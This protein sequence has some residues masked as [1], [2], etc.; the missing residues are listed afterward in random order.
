MAL[1]LAWGTTAWADSGWTTALPYT[2]GT[3]LTPN[4]PVVGGT[5]YGRI[6]RLQNSGN[7]NGTLIATFEAWPYDM[8]I[9]QSTDDGFTWT[10]IATTTET[11]FPGWAFKVEPDLFELP[12]AMGSLPA[13]TILLAGNA[14]NGNGH[15]LE[16][17]FS[18]DHGYTWHYRGMADNNSATLK[19]LWEPRLGASSSGQLVCYYSDERFSP[20]YNQLLGERVSPDGGLTW[21]AEQYVCAIPDAVQRPGMAVTTK[22]PNGQYVLSFEAVGTPTL[23]QVHIKFSPDG[24][25]WGTG[26]TDY[27]TPVQTASG[28][29]VGACPYITWCPAGGSNGTLVINAQFLLNSPNTDREILINTN[30]GQGSWTMMPAPVQWQGGGNILAGWS[31][32]MIPT[33]DGQGIIQLASSVSSN[34]NNNQMLFGREQLVLP[35][36]VYNYFNQNSG[37]ALGIPGNSSVPGTG[38][39]QAV[40]NG[41]PAQQWIFSDQG[42]NVWTVTNPGNQLAWDDLAWNTAPG[43]TVDEFTY[44]GLPVQQWRLRPVGNGSWKFISVNAGLPLSVTN[45]S[46][47]PGAAIVLGTNASK[48]EQNWFPAQPVTAPAAVYAL[49]GTSL[50][51]SGNG[52]QGTFLPNVPNFMAGRIGPQAVQ[53]NGVNNYLQIPR[54]IGAGSGFAIAFWLKTTATGGPGTNWYNGA[55]LVDGNLTAVTNDFG[56]ALLNGKIAFGIGN[57]DTTLP[58]S[59]TV[60]DGLWHHVMA[61]RNALNGLMSLYIDGNLNTNAFGPVGGRMSPLNLRIGSLQTGG[62]GGFFNGALDEV[63]LYNGWLAT[64]QIMAL[65][66]VNS[67]NWAA[68]VADNW[69]TA[70]RWTSSP[71]VPG[72][73]AG[74]YAGLTFDLSAPRTITIDTTS[75]TVGRLNLGDPT[76]PYFG[77]TLAA[78]GGAQLTFNNSGAGASL[79]QTGSQATDV[80]TAPLILADTLTISNTATLTLAGPLT[81]N[82]GSINKS[83]SGTVRLAALD[84][85]PGNTFVK[86]GTL[87]VDTGG[88]ITNSTFD[89]VGQTTGDNATV[90]LQGRGTWSTASDFNAGDIGNS[91]GIVNITDSATLTANALFIGSAN[92]TAS[93]AT[94][95][96]N[97]TNG[98]VT[99]LSPYDGALVIGGRNGS[100]ALGAG[101]Y[102]LYGGALNVNNGGNAWIGGYGTGAFNVTG[103]QATLSGYVSV[104]RWPGAT[105]SL[106]ISGGSVAQTNT[107]RFTLIGEAG[108]GSLNLSGTGQ[109]TV[110]GMQLL[111]GNIAGTGTGTVNLNGGLLVAPKIVSG[112]GTSTINFN[113]GTLAA[114]APAASFMTGLTA[115]N[116][117]AGGATLDDGGFAITIGQPLLNGGSGGLTK[118]GTGT[119]TLNGI[120]TYTG[121][122]LISSG[123]L[124]LGP[125]GSLPGTALM[126]VAA[127]ASFDVT[128]LG[129]PFALGAGQVLSNNAAATG[130]L[131]GSFNTGSGVVYLSYAAGTP[132][133]I[134]TSGTLSL[135]AATTV[136]VN[137]VGPVLGAGSYELIAP[138]IGGAVSGPL[139]AVTA[140][141][142]GAATASLAAYSGGL[143]LVVNGNTAPGITNFMHSVDGTNLNLAWP[144]NLIGWRLVVQT[145]HLSQGVSFNLTDYSTVPGSAA[146]NRLTVPI[147]P[148]LPAE[149]YRLVYP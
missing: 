70:S 19:G 130:T 40:G 26:P 138:G 126:S 55:G 22:L 93:S 148:A 121:N 101:N 108:T 107:S 128:G 75:R 46:T 74:D 142:L 1:A 135:S 64:N 85:C 94:G 20:T 72:N 35:G 49:D 120:N 7:A 60:N 100:S 144:A 145:N 133:F 76:A 115:A 82:G 69:S 106:N 39:Q 77:Y 146:T 99:T 147:N 58:S 38:L 12:V 45:A 102:N 52:Y 63:R 5:R 105:G 139:P 16:I 73:H 67:G 98:T 66:Q 91:L 56:V 111:L 129:A 51:S 123:T 68:D 30:L 14:E 48:A 117:L 127:G 118:L 71:L 32:G 149:F 140:H 143:W 96:I 27:G 84:A 92:A 116:I 42:N 109:F 3:I 125:G 50:D 25:N 15:Q 113:G 110:A 23:S 33:A 80:I 2:T 137:N 54:S 65:A 141:G 81:G 87:V 21:G 57:P 122:T 124:A 97:Q 90:V 17:Y 53:L 104:G 28:A 8:G 62:A 136:V 59:V 131:K 11:Q 4:S 112:A 29:Y 44:N 132:A 88:A 61:A 83:G 78:S 134:I 13:G 31:Q 114:S 34:T 41:S 9:Y 86:A 36:N 95:I 119:T 89:D 18:L 24:T 37:L 6:I 103:G 79:V 10:Q 43:T 47:S